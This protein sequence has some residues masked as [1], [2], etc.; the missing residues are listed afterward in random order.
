MMEVFMGKCR[1]SAVVFY[2]TLF[3]IMTLS[4][5]LYQCT[6]KSPS[7]PVWD[8]SLIVPLISEMYT[9]EKLGDES[10]DIEIQGDQVLFNIDHQLDPIEM[11]DFLRINGAEKSTN[12]PIP[13]SVIIGFQQTVSDVVTMPDSII[14]TNAV[15]KQGN[16][17]VSVDNQTNY[18]INI[19][20]VIPFLQQSGNALPI[21]FD[22]NSGDYQNWNIPLDQVEFLP[23]GTNQVGF[24]ATARVTG[25]TGSQGGNVFITVRISDI[26]F[27]ELTGILD[28]LHLNLED[29]NMEIGLP[30]ELEGFRIQSANL[31][32][33]LRLGVRIPIVTD[34]SIEA[35]N[36]RN[37]EFIDQISF[38]DSITNVVGN[39][40]MVDTLE[41]PND[42]LVAD[43]INGQ[44]EEIAVDG[45]LQIGDGQN[46]VTVYDTNT[47]DVKVLFKAPLIVTL[48]DYITETNPDTIDIDEDTREILRDNLISVDLETIIDNHLPLGVRVTIFYD[49]TTSDSATLYHPGYTPNLTIGPLEMT[50]APVSG[51]PGLVTAPVTSMLDI[52]LNKDQLRLF[53]RPE[54]YQGTRLEILGTSG[55]MVQVRPTDY[56]NIRAILNAVVRTKIPEDEDDDEEGGGE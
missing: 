16:V 44:P 32:L 49:S 53:E 20:V 5:F 7:A 31:K 50:P 40:V 17:E 38:Q 18:H 13:N 28:H 43:F 54:I 33:A 36:Q 1:R 11:G 55:Q 12:I 6:F 47:V 3:G 48:P 25:S 56:I 21:N 46:T 35:I 34:L 14:V 51:T 9:M 29:Q 26:Q 23:N 4:L 30:D 10:D 19:D 24:D 8:V 2:L 39:G 42:L 41:F 27:Q 22:I 37:P 52:E 15:I 45:S